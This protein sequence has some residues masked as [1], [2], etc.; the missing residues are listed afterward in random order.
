[1]GAVLP[2]GLCSLLNVGENKM[3]LGA[4]F[5]VKDRRDV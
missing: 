3:A 1:M 2:G 5:G 4:S